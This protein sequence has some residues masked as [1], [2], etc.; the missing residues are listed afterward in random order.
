MEEIIMGLFR[1]E[2][3]ERQQFEAAYHHWFDS[4]FKSECRRLGVEDLETQKF[5]EIHQLAARRA[6]SDTY[7]PGQSSRLSSSDIQT[8]YVHKIR[9]NLT[10]SLRERKERE[11]RGGGVAA[12]PFDEPP[13]YKSVNSPETQ[14]I[15]NDSVSTFPVT[16][17]LSA[18]DR[19]LHRKFGLGTVL[20]VGGSAKRSDATIDFDS[21]VVR[22][23]LLRYAQES[24]TKL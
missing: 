8:L 4:M 16:L 10:R 19:V 7:K 5:Q 23:L 22:R 17:S 3:K 14:A 15:R 1:S 2:T 12:A 9:E 13:G 6:V 18:G 20:E 21:G 11:S 24:I